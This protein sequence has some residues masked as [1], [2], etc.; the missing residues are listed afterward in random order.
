MG[1]NAQAR[2][3]REQAPRSVAPAGTV[4]GLDGYSEWIS[5][6]HGGVAGALGCGRQLLPIGP[7][8][9]S[10]PDGHG[11][12]R[13]RTE[14]LGA[15]DELLASQALDPPQ[16]RLLVAAVTVAAAPPTA[17]LC[18]LL[19]V[20]LGEPAVGRAAYIL[21]AMVAGAVAPLGLRGQYRLLPGAAPSLEDAMRLEFRDGEGWSPA[22]LCGVVTSGSL[23]GA[24]LDADRHVAFALRL[25]MERVP[26]RH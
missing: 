14:L 10:G 13:L 22:G 12:P 15:V 24:G 18:Q 23:E 5:A 20:Y 8:Q 4:A 16:A 17:R 1:V 2:L 7:W 3:A 11:P 26:G 6:V 19:L 21:P 25:T 9:G